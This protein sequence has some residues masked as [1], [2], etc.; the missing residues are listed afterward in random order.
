M[1]V[2]VTMAVIIG[3]IHLIRRASSFRAGLAIALCVGVLLG[4]I[5]ASQP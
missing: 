1:T 2:F 4:L 5:V 3:G